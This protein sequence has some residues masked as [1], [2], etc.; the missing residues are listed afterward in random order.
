VDHAETAVTTVE[1]HVDQSGGE[2]TRQACSRPPPA[3]GSEDSIDRVEGLA[4]VT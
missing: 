4:P 3:G 2:S 1:L